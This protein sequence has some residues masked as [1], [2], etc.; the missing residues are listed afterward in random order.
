MA[1]AGESPHVCRGS[2]LASSMSKGGPMELLLVIGIGYV[3]WRF[4]IKRDSGS[5]GRTTQPPPPKGRPAGGAAFVYAT[6][7][8]EGREGWPPAVLKAVEG[9]FEIASADEPTTLGKMRTLAKRSAKLAKT[10]ADHLEPIVTSLD[11][12]REDPDVPDPVVDALQ[13]LLDA[14]DA[15]MGAEYE[16]EDAEDEVEV[17]VV[18]YAQEFADAWLAAPNP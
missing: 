9:I 16:A 4:V 14:A 15:L 10:V 18:G 7:S 11:E 5:R 12:A 17:D 13:R 6:F 8:A 3:V 1:P 2:R